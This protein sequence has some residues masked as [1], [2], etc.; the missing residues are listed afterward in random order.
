[1]TRLKNDI[2]SFIRSKHLLDMYVKQDHSLFNDHY[3]RYKIDRIEWIKKAIQT[4]PK[5]QTY[6]AYV[7][8][9]LS[10][11]TNGEATEVIRAIRGTPKKKYPRK[12]KE[13]KI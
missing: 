4:F 6:G 11:L 13:V 5:N 9:M 3:E 1:M 8:I 10:R 7:G 12:K 2:I